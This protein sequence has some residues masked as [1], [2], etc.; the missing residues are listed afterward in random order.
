MGKSAQLVA[1]GLLLHVTTGACF[2]PLGEV[3]D[4]SAVSHPVSQLVAARPSSAW[5]S[6]RRSAG[7]TA[8]AL[9]GLGCGAV[10]LSAALRRQ[11]GSTS[12][13]Q[14]KAVVL[15]AYN[16]SQ[17]IGACDPLLFWD[18]IGFCEGGTKEDFDRRRA[19]ELKHGRLSM[20]ACLG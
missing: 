2:V 7:L 13:G 16:A 9:L 19:V 8:S 12:A 5:V 6:E 1:V 20:L 4:G 14:N 15:S 17:E 10:A 11:R 3:R 18:P